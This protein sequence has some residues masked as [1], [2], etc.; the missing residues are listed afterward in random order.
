[1]PGRGGEDPDAL[2]R[3]VVA[4]MAEGLVVRDAQG[5]V[6]F[7]NRRA[8]ELLGLPAEAFEPDAVR[9]PRW[10]AHSEDGRPQTPEDWPAFVALRTGRSQRDVILRITRPDGSVRWVSANA[11]PLLP[12][13]GGPPEGAVNTFADITERRLRE[14]ERRRH[15]LQHAAVAELGVLALGRMSTARLMR[16]AAAALATNLGLSAAAVLEHDARRAELRAV[17]AV[18]DVPQ[19][20]AAGSHTLGAE[21]LATATA[22]RVGDLRTGARRASDP[23]WSAT[24]HRCAIGAPVRIGGEAVAAL[25]GFGPEPR[26][27]SD[28]DA[29]F[30]QTVANVVASALERE[31]AEDRIRHQALHDAL[32]GLPNRTLVL[33]RLEHALERCRAD[34][35]AGRAAV[36]RPRPLQGRQRLAGPRTSA[37]SC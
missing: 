6:V 23:A 17:A 31:H 30:A 37:T 35:P 1:M 20:M 13:G 27:F 4:T 11:E 15:A 5:R 3:T 19:T 32:T 9:D 22:A 21:V 16:E 8:E 26:A 36:P 14:E 18:G 10:Q 28:T 29:S 7:M 33:E 2:Y 24:T 34:G 12:P 25:I